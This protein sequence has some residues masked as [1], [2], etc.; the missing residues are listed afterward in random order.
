MKIY[1]S[2]SRH[3]HALLGMR[4]QD[5]GSQKVGAHMPAHGAGSAD[6]TVPTACASK[7]TP[8]FQPQSPIPVSGPAR[9]L[10]TCV[11][12]TGVGRLAVYP[13]AC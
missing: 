13:P 7:V 11:V 3:G 5:A 6:H 8:T 4:D 9:N 1:P 2:W 10:P 12:L